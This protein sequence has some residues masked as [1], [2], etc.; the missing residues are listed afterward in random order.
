MESNLVDRNSGS[1][2][3]R[4][5]LLFTVNAKKTISRYIHKFRMLGN[6]DTAVISTPYILA[7]QL[8]MHPHEEWLIMEFLLH[9]P[10]KTIAEILDEVYIY[11]Y[12]YIYICTFCRFCIYM[13]YKTCTYM[14]I[15]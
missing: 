14:T 1:W 9:H 5:E 7:Y 2:C 11:I 12:I 15:S 4:S 8:S 6:V 13:T 10:E 3:S